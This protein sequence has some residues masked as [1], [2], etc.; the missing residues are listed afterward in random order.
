MQLRPSNKALEL[1]NRPSAITLEIAPKSSPGYLVAGIAIGAVSG[2]VVGSIVTLLIGEKS[3]L[4][5]QHLWNRVT[6]G[7]QDGERVHFEL[8]LQ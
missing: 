7:Q 2:F 3:L 8:L 6:S 1:K 4:L 5:V